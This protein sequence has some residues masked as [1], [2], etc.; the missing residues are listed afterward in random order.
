MS[1]PSPPVSVKAPAPALPPLIVEPAE[2]AVNVALPAS[3]E[4]F[5]VAL[6]AV[7]LIIPV[8]VKVAPAATTTTSLS[9]PPAPPRSRTVSVPVLTV[10]ISL[11]APPVIISLPALPLI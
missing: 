1:T 5:S 4:L 11:P 3:V 7:K 2:A 10:I 8:A 6:V 9:E